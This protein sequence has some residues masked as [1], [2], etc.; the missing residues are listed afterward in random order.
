M[1]ADRIR[2]LASRFSDHTGDTGEHE[3]AVDLLVLTVFANREVSQDELDEL[4]RF[5][6]EHSNWDAGAFS[7]GQYLPEAL[8]KVRNA[9]EV[10]D[11]ENRILTDSAARITTPALRTEIAEACA[12]LA[13]KGGTD[14]AESAFLTR[15]RSAL[16]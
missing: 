16:G 6:A 1:L 11:G 8:A 10:D 14:Q 9:I 2:Q 12:S 5:D 7:V 13:S 4:N 15:L 3:A